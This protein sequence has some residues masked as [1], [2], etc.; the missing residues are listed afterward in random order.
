[1]NY[2]SIS[3]AWTMYEICF[4]EM[5]FDCVWNIVSMRW[6]LMMYEICFM[7][8]ELCFNELNFDDIW[9]MFQ[10]AE[11]DDVWNMLQ[12]AELWWCMKYVSIRWNLMMYELCINE[13]NFVHVY[14]NL[15]SS[16]VSKYKTLTSAQVVFIQD[17]VLWRISVIR[18]DDES[19]K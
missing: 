4:H 3:W 9:P 10:W 7:M 16:M 8:Y 13:L 5:N 1:M 12:L 19:Q 18:V 2:V 6:I 11:F 14:G 15:L 17:N